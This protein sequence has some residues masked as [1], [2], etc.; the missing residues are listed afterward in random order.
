ML[1]FNKVVR[2]PKKKVSKG[3]KVNFTV[4]YILIFTQFGLWDLKR[5]RHKI[6]LMSSWF[7]EI[8]NMSR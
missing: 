7:T 3:K 6:Y 2:K 1:D 4:I 8:K 5:I